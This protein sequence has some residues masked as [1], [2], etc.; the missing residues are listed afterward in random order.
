M[1]IWSCWCSKWKFFININNL[2]NVNEATI[3]VSGGV[4]LYTYIWNTIPIQ[5]T[6]TATGLNY[7]TLYK[8]KVTDS[9]GCIRIIGIQY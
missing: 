2:K 4:P 5:T 1:D 3:N 8:C 9:K 7:G 6:S